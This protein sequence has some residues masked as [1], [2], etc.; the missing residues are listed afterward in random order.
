MGSQ[1][2]SSG[3][4][5]GLPENQNKPVTCSTKACTCRAPTV[6][7]N[8]DRGCPSSS[9]SKISG[10]AIVHES[11]EVMISLNWSSVTAEHNVAAQV[12]SDYGTLIVH[13][14]TLFL[15]AQPSLVP[16][17]CAKHLLSETRPFQ[18]LHCPATSTPLANP[19][20]SPI[21]VKIVRTNGLVKDNGLVDCM[22]EESRVVEQVRE[23]PL[24]E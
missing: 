8:S 12:H 3:W 10:S 7:R 15:P 18:P 20:P 13:R 21:Q 6:G 17:R 2:Q 11:G 1:C 16:I 24:E 14:L 23:S 19:G 9:S 4:A 5:G 22:R